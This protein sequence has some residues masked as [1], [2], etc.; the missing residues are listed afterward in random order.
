MDRSVDRAVAADR[1]RW[2][3]ELAQAVDQ[4]QRWSLG[5][6]AAGFPEIK[7]LYRRLDAIRI[8]V[9]DLRRGRRG[10]PLSEIDP[11]W[12]NLFAFGRPKP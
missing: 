1:A 12:T 6:S 11:L 8:E 3:A 7:D 9:E 4:A 10:V 2:L 5:A